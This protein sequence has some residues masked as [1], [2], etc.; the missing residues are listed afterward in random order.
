MPPARRRG[1]ATVQTNNCREP[2]PPDAR[3]RSGWRSAAAQAR[4]PAPPRSSPSR[5]PPAPAAGRNAPAWY[6]ARRR[7]CASAAR[8]AARSARRPA[9]RA[10][11]HGSAHTARS[12]APAPPARNRKRRRPAAR[13]GRVRWP[14]AARRTA[15]APRRARC[16]RAGNAEC[17]A[18]PG[19]AIAKAAAAVWNARQRLGSGG[20]LASSAGILDKKWQVRIA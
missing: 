11:A 15:P 3:T 17:R 2:A 20:W 7:A 6:R 1:P 19:S 8:C 5:F 9:R 18:R 14:S 4:S 16:S 12:P 13:S 10:P